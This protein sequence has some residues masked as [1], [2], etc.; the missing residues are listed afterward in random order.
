MGIGESEEYQY[1]DK[2]RLT[3]NWYKNNGFPFKKGDIFTVW[4]QYSTC[5]STNR[6]D[7]DLRDLELIEEGFYH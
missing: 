7:F 1:G 5:V 2:V 4:A 3:T 6:A